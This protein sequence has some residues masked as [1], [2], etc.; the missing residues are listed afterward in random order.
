MDDRTAIVTGAAS[1]IGRATAVQLAE[2]GATVV[3][4]D[5]D[6]D[7]VRKTADE[8]ADAGAETA[9]YELNVADRDRFDEVVDDVTEQFGGVDVLVNNAGVLRLSRFEETPEA[10]FD[11]QFDEFEETPEA[12]FD[13]QFD[14]NLKGVWNGCQAVVPEMMR[15]GGGSIVNTASVDGITGSPFHAPY[16]AAKAAVINLTRTLAVEL[17]GDGV[18]INAV[19]PGFVATPPVEHHIQSQDDPDAKREAM[20]AENALGRLSD[21]AEIAECIVF[22]A[23]ERASFVT[24][25]DFVVDAGYRHAH[26][27]HFRP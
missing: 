14:V 6:G 2:Q 11:L 17:G 19:C 4:T 15:S 5:I 9:S 18:R 24:G 27:T 8:L 21:P 16:G 13:L 25:E 26:E 7:G 1:G 3:A 12:D 22:L 20:A 10:D 23:S